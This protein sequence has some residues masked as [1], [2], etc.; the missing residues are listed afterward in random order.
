MPAPAFE[1][2]VSEFRV[3]GLLRMH[4]GGYRLESDAEVNCL[5]I[6]DAAL[7]S[8]GTIRERANFAAL[9]TEQIIV[10]TPGELNAAKA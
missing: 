8:A 1:G 3:H 10:L 4:D 6:R 9:C 5:A 7:D 2:G